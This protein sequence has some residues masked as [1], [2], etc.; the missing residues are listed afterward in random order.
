MLDSQEIH[1]PYKITFENGR[2]IAIEIDPSVEIKPNIPPSFD[3]KSCVVTENFGVFRMQDEMKSFDTSAVSG[4]LDSI[5]VSG[6]A[7]KEG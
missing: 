6:T 4:F 2:V 3:P 1:K 5:A 7:A